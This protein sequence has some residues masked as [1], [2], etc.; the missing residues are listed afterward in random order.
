MKIQIKVAA[1][2]KQFAKMVGIAPQKQ[3]YDFRCF[4]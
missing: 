4:V 1:A 2:N 3:Q